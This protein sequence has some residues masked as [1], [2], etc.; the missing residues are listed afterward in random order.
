MILSIS[1]RNVWRNKLRSLIMITAITLGLCAGIFASAFYLGMAD[2]RIEKAIKTEISHVQIHQPEFLQ[3]NDISKF[4][5]QGGAIAAQ[6]SDMPSVTGVSP[7]IVIFSMIGSAETGSGVKIVG[8]YPDLERQTTNLHTKVIEG[9]YF[10]ENKRNSIVIGHKLAEKLKVKLGSKVVITLQDVENNI[11]SGAFRITGIFNS[12]NTGYDEGNVFVRYEDL[13]RLTDFP[14]GA[15]H[16]IAVL[17][18][19]NEEV[20][21]LKQQIDNLL[22]GYQNDSAALQAR[23]WYQV[24]PEMNYLVESMDLYMYIFIAIILLALL[25]GI[26]NT[27]LMAVLD[28]AKELGMLMAI[29]MSRIRV[30]SMVVVE[31]VFLSLTGGVA[32][33]ALGYLV[34]K[35]F[36]T[37]RINLAAWGEVY[38]DLGYDPFVYTTIEWSYLINTTVMVII[39]GIIASIYPAIKALKNDPAEA[40]RIE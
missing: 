5:G 31:T 32:G 24:S 30:F 34:A 26:I 16:E 21:G 23:T 29:G 40:L 28:R 35:Y 8:I 12:L 25:F 11:T 22:T 6:I 1:W 19:S 37:H 36:E 39:T 4:I 33:I 15:C 10:E 13:A 3:S 20:D 9:D 17:A 14:A 38:T 7:R 2:Q 18:K 27:M